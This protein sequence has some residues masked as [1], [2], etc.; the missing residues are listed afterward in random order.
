VA[1]QCFYGCSV[2]FMAAQ[3]FFIAGCFS[4]FITSLWCSAFDFL[5]N[6]CFLLFLSFIVYACISNRAGSMFWKLVLNMQKKHGKK[7]LSR[8]N[9]VCCLSSSSST[10]WEKGKGRVHGCCWELERLVVRAGWCQLPFTQ[11]HLFLYM[12]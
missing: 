2:F 7:D 1:V 9:P 11:S 5:L 12:L 6:F 3:C 10:S 8:R 4:V